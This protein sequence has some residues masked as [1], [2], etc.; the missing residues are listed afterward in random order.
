KEYIQAKNI[1]E[2][3][4]FLNRLPVQPEVVQIVSSLPFLY[5]NPLD[6]IAKAKEL[7]LNENL[8]KT[9]AN[10]EEIYE[11]LEA[12]GV[13]NHVVIDL[14]LINHMDY[15][16]DMIFQGFIEKVGKPILMGGRYDTLA[17]QFDANLPAIGFACDVD[18]L[19]LGIEQSELPQMNPSDAAILFDKKSEKR[20]RQ[21]AALLR[22]DGYRVVTYPIETENSRVPEAQAANKVEQERNV[23]SFEGNEHAFY[24]NEEVLSMLNEMKERK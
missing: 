21:L 8:K 17:N 19:I 9:L 5:G 23:L 24:K 20:G 7:P 3:N 14:S 13:H 2:I 15:Y 18:A 11:V 1:T 6:V 12:Y 16:S 10:I 22:D 4:Q